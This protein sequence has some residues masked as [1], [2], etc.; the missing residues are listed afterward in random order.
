M[1]YQMKTCGFSAF[2]PVENKSAVRKQVY[3]FFPDINSIPKS[4]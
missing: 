3:S 4:F 1:N 2:P